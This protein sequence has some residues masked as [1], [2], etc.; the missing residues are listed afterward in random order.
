MWLWTQNTSLDRIPTKTVQSNTR[1]KKMLFAVDRYINIVDIG[2]LGF[3][4]I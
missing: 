1:P 3:Y 2:L 4:A